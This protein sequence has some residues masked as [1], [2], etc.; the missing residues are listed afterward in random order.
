MKNVLAVLWNRALGYVFEFYEAISSDFKSRL[1]FYIVPTFVGLVL[2]ALMVLP[3]GV[4]IIGASTGY[5]WNHDANQEFIGQVN[6]WYW[7]RKS[8]LTVALLVM[9]GFGVGLWH[10]LLSS[11]S[12]PAGLALLLAYITFVA[13][14]TAT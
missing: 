3:V 4:P 10:R 12:K 6:K 8:L 2:A 7:Y 5:F 14:P 1:L 11:R 13:V 9:A